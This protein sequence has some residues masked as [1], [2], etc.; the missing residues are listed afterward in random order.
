M[1]QVG[2]LVAAC[3][4]LS[5]NTWAPYLQLV[6]SLVVAHQLRSCGMRTPSCSMHVGSSSLT[7]DPTRAP[8]IGSAESYPLHHQGSPWKPSF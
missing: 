2:S 8:C 4:L 6:G 7:R 5:C 3:R 1:Q